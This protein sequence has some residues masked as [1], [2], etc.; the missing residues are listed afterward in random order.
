MGRKRPRVCFDRK[1]LRGSRLR[2]LMLTAMP[3]KHVAS[4]L[5][6]L[7]GPCATVDADR[8]KWTPS[9]FLQPQEARLGRTREFLS[10]GDRNEVLRWWLRAGTNT[11]S[12]DIVSTCDFDGQPGLLLVEA[13]AHDQELAEEDRC[14]ATHPG[15]VCQIG[16]AL[17][18]AS[19]ELEQVVPGWHLSR[20]SHYQLSNRFAWSWKIASLGIP[21]VLVYLGFLDA[22][23]MADQ[24]R[25]FGSPKDWATA[26]RSYSSGVVPADGVWERRIEINGTPM[27]ALTRSLRLRCDVFKD[28]T[29]G[30]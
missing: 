26:V 14:H 29:E 1:D 22:E 23:E 28:A 4:W 19:A 30:G 8:H 10:C 24:G 17:S 6:K 5:T 12:W 13:K 25:P 21:V 18:K 7:G 20:D 2:C 11:P 27:C 15:N 9:G 3:R 16:K